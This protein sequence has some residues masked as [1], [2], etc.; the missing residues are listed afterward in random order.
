TAGVTGINQIFNVSAYDPDAGDSIYVEFAPPF[1]NNNV[2]VVFDSAYSKDQPFG[3][4][5]AT[6]IDPLTGIL[7]V[8][9]APLGIYTVGLKVS[10]YYNGVLTSIIRRDVPFQFQNA[11]TP[12]AIALSNIGGQATY[13]QNGPNYYFEMTENDTLKFDLSASSNAL[14]GGQ[15]IDVSLLGYGDLLTNNAAGFGNCV[16]NNCANFTSTTGSFINPAIT[17]TEFKFVPDTGFVNGTNQA[18]HKTIS[19]SSGV[20][21]SCG[22]SRLNSIGIYIKVNSIGSIYSQPTYQS[23]KGTGVHANIQGDTN[24]IVWSPIHGVANINS[25]TTLL[26][27]DSSMTYTVTHVPSGDAINVTVLVDSLGM[28][29]FVLTNTGA[30]LIAPTLDPSQTVTWYYNGSVLPAT[31]DSIPLDVT[32][33]Y[34]ASITNGLCIIYSDTVK[35]LVS[36]KASNSNDQGSAIN[37]QA[38]SSNFTFVLN[39]SGNTLEDIELVFPDSAANKTAATVTVILKAQGAIVGTISAV[40]ISDF[41]W[42]ASGFNQVIAPGIPHEVVVNTDFAQTVLF[43]P[44]SLPFNSDDG[45]LLIAAGSYVENGQVI[46]GAYPYANFKFSSW[47]S[48]EE[49]SFDVKFY[50]NPVDEFL[51]IDVQGKAQFRLLDINGKLMM[52][53]EV[54]GNDKVDVSDLASGIYI[55]EIDSDVSV[56]TGKLIV[57]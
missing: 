37:T 55:Y 10:S 40:K 8:S 16:G 38:G 19:F 51:N 45:L 17:N 6:S 25:A 27:P 44:Q 48:L 18:V 20:A 33:N 32:G 46:Q 42:R 29:S 49:E 9:S 54:I 53:K 4:A 1:T 56:T 57:K 7:S 14:V 24:N 35:A 3:T 26:D 21:D 47:L 34:W 22:V 31:G 23:C 2:P 11:Q 13:T 52:S 43:S 39:Q 15:P 12:P 30:E 28:S 41:V 36:L 50:P 5:V